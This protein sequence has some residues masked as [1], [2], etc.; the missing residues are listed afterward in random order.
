MRAFP[1][2]LTFGQSRFLLIKEAIFPVDCLRLWIGTFLA[3]FCGHALIDYLM[4]EIKGFILISFLS[5]FLINSKLFILFQLRVFY[6][7]QFILTVLG[8]Y[9]V[10]VFIFWAI[11]NIFEWKFLLVLVSVRYTEV[12]RLLINRLFAPLSINII[13]AI[14]LSPLDL[15]LNIH[16]LFQSLCIFSSELLVFDLDAF[17]TCV[18]LSWLFCLLLQDRP[19]DWDCHW[20]GRL[21]ELS[22]LYAF[23]HFHV[24]IVQLVEVLLGP[25][26]VVLLGDLFRTGDMLWPVWWP[27]LW[28]LDPF[29]HLHIFIVYLVQI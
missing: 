24:F 25:R 23:V 3:Y 28:L 2:L 11:L 12:N 19:S 6:W 29:M 8:Q 17:C 7:Y 10:G 1:I 5:N 26:P 9:L 20:Y 18:M 27:K 22:S 16:R 4:I 15:Y 14:A 13:T 21:T